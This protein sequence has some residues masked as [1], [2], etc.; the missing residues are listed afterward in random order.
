[1][2]RTMIPNKTKLGLQSTWLPSWWHRQA[3]R[4]GWRQVQYDAIGC[5]DISSIGTIVLI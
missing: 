1:M 4:V 5:A 2:A 3:L